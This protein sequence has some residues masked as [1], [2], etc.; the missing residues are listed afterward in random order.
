MSSMKALQS[1]H[2]PDA[3]RHTSQSSSNYNSHLSIAPQYGTAAPQQSSTHSASFPTLVKPL[4][5]S[6]H[7]AVGSRAQSSYSFQIPDGLLQILVD[8]ARDKKRKR[9][10]GASARF[11]QRRKGKKLENARTIAELERKVRDL[12]KI[13]EIYREE[14]DNFYN[15]IKSGGDSRIGG[16]LTPSSGF[17]DKS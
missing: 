16:L 6:S 15:L 12:T 11:R 13:C 4:A 14:R 7:D 2:S 3:S 9:N 1:V 5:L 10:A 17:S 8:L